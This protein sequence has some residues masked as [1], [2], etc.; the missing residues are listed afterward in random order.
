MEPT[1]NVFDAR[2]LGVVVAR[3]GV[4]CHPNDAEI[5]IVLL[6]LFQTQK[7]NREEK[8]KKNEEK[9][10]KKCS[11]KISP[12]IRTDQARRSWQRENEMTVL[13][14]LSYLAKKKTLSCIDLRGNTSL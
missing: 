3:R 12:E 2:K 9:G 13:P 7:S 1:L 11:K 6:L 8:R 10:P 14:S 4:R 5:W